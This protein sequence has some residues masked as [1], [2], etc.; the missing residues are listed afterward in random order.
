MN[1]FSDVRYAMRALRRNP[2]FATVV[3]LI[4]GIGIGANAAMFSIV[5]GILLKPLAFH[6]PSRLVAVQESVFRRG[7][8]MP[9]PVNAMHFNEWR[10]NWR[11]A[12]Q[13]ALLSSLR[14]NLVS[15]GEPESVAVGRVSWSL[16]PLLGIQLALGRNFLEAEDRAG[17]DHEVILSDSLWRQR[18]QG[19]PGILG[20][21]VLLNG[22]L[23]EVIGILPPGI[24][25][26]KVRELQS[27]TFGAEAP[28]I[29]KPF[30]LPD[31]EL[32]PIG[33]FDF[34]CIAR[35]RPNVSVEQATSE[36]NAVQAEFSRRF[37]DGV[38]LRATLTPLREQITGRSREG[39]LLLLLSVGVVL[40][41]VSFNVANLLLARGAGRRQEF[42]LRAAIGASST[43]LLRQTL[44]E[45]FVTAILGGTLGI[46]IAVG[47]L[48]LAM[49]LAPID[50]P[51]LSEVHIDAR[52]VAVAFLLSLI[53]GAICASMPAWLSLRSDPQDGLRA[54]GR[55]STDGR[56]VRRL[57]SLLVGIE[58]A[59]CT[60]CL[61]AAGLL[62]NSFVRLLNVDKG[63]DAGHVIT[64]DL[65]MPATRY[66][67]TAHRTEF[68]RSAIQAA[69]AMPGVSAVGISNLLPLDG[70]GSNNIINV[71]GDTTPFYQRPIADFRLVNEDFFRAIGIPLLRGRTIQ[72]S[73]ST[74]HVSV[75]SSGLAQRLWPNEDPLGKH[76]HLGDPKGPAL[77]VVGIAGDVRAAHLQSLPNP[78]VYLPYWQRD[79][80]VMSLI[81]RTPNDPVSVAASVRAIIRELNRDMPVNFRTLD[82]IVSASVAQRRFQLNLVLLFAAV[83][84]GL[85]ALGIYGVV[86]YS[87]VQRRNEFGVRMAL[88]ATTYR[89]QALVV[90]QGLAPVAA[91]VSAGLAGSIVGGRLLTSLLYGITPNDLTTLSAVAGLLLVVAGIA[92][93]LPA[94]QA[95]SSDPSKALRHD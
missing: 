70:E 57:R 56:S 67:D 49:V 17:A 41:I 87:V 86:S 51:R 27:M 72:A 18:F 29:W 80:A 7:Q 12:E 5:D 79:R 4:L 30:A 2:G 33:D 66:P 46:V 16:F 73:D 89:L 95:A 19:N 64:V 92:C 77:E 8:G 32:Y 60:I 91:G 88:G 45:S 3:I 26:P 50:L 10:R 37:A 59:L 42:A 76:F 71:D 55:N 34:A 35:L 63:F 21:T 36:L 74:G 69:A 81:V 20:R 40:L 65:N 24:Q 23:Y 78:T 61:A 93:W 25:I 48:R 22:S 43:Q 54:S 94:L 6:N 31:D 47:A 14:M 39:L 28:L 13:L 15:D 38:D 53:S 83:A 1:L 90:R 52:V 82:E 58:T 84:L 75:I 9:G 85:A 62:L 44:T 68:L 11:S